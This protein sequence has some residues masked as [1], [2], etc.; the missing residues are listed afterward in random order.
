MSGI[1]LPKCCVPTCNCSGLGTPKL[2]MDAVV[3]GVT[4]CSCY[5]SSSTRSH[6]CSGPSPNGTWTNIPLVTPG[7]IDYYKLFSTASNTC[8]EYYSSGTCSGPYA[9]YWQDFVSF[10][11]QCNRGK[12]SFGISSSGSYIV[13]TGNLPTPSV[14]AGTTIVIPNKITSSACD[15]DIVGAIDAYGGSA[16]LTFHD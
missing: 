4:L 3:T 16:T 2:Y 11:V 9:L 7:V 1:L 6:W 15:A 12:T 13:F 14:C 10:R 5:R 8:V